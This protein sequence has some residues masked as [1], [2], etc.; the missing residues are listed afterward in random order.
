LALQPKATL[1]KQED[2]LESLL[3]QQIRTH[4]VPIFL[5]QVPQQEDLQRH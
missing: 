4:L 3:N 2:Y 1:A 5:A